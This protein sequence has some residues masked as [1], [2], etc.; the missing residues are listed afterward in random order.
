MAS[1]TY[2]SA[3][4]DELIA[5]VEA[6]LQRCNVLTDFAESQVEERVR[7]ARLVN[8]L[9]SDRD[10]LQAANGELRQ[11]VELLDARL[12]AMDRSMAVRLALVPRRLLR[13][14]RRS[15]AK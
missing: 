12:R 9:A 2:D 11:Q 6:Y 13:L 4:V 14:V 15:A 1:P 3:F 5:D 10:G 7:L 8:R